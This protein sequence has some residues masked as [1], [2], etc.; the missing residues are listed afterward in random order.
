LRI[1]K[2]V[3]YLYNKIKQIEIMKAIIEK[4][5]TY[6]VTGEKGVFTITEDVKGKIKMFQTS[7]IE[8][9]EINEM[10]K[11]KVYKKNTSTKVS[12]DTIYQKQQL[13]D[14]KYS[15]GIYKHQ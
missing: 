9:L 15:R 5:I 3:V 1:Q 14:A 7:T 6:R 11:A 2:H 4:G 10:P 13:Q 12:A 8:V